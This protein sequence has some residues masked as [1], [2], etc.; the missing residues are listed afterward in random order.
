MAHLLSEQM[1]TEPHLC[2]RHYVRCD[3]QY[4]SCPHGSRSLT[5]EANPE[6]VMLTKGDGAY[7]RE[8]SSKG[9]GPRPRH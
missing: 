4:G 7:D 9:T 2:A 8:A 1:F 5:G 6:Q 3:K